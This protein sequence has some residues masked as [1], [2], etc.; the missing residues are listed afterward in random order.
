MVSNH[1]ILP[2]G[3]ISYV[4]YYGSVLLS[5]PFGQY[6]V[7]VVCTYTLGFV[8]IVR[9]KCFQVLSMQNVKFFCL[10][11]KVSIATL[12]KNPSRLSQDVLTPKNNLVG[13]KPASRDVGEVPGESS[14]ILMGYH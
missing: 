9:H 10:D 13:S 4:P 3:H 11:L 2:D 1:S 7:S 6:V 12:L 8:T 14:Y 5:L